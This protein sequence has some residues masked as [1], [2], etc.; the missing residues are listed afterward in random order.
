MYQPPLPYLFKF[1]MT[2]HL[3][4]NNGIRKVLEKKWFASTSLIFFQI[5]F[6]PLSKQKII[7]LA[8][9][10]QP[11]VLTLS[12]RKEMYT[13]HRGYCVKLTWNDH[14]PSCLT[15]PFE[16]SVILIDSPTDEEPEYMPPAAGQQRH[17]KGSNRL[18]VREGMDNKSFSY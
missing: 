12:A 2:P 7:K 15:L 4:E 10:L 5:C 16:K 9:T 8:L 6:N 18:C 1:V 14:S 17:K 13:V 3:P 11:P